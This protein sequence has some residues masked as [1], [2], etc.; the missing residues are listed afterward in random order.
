MGIKMKRYPLRTLVSS[1]FWSACLLYNKEML[2]AKPKRKRPPGRLEAVI[3]AQWIQRNMGVMTAVAVERT[4]VI[5]RVN[6]NLSCVWHVQNGL[7]V[8]ACKISSCCT[9]KG[10]I[11]LGQER[12]ELLPGMVKCYDCYFIRK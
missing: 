5:S 1:Y 8:S 3:W 7:T 6:N 2:T 9:E 10:N 4:D 12:C 11:S